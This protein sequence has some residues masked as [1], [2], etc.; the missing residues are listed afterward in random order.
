MLLKMSM[1][2]PRVTR[3]DALKPSILP[4]TPGA[5]L[6]FG[7]LSA[8]YVKDDLVWVKMQP[9]IVRLMP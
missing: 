9:L 3:C 6:M 2:V 8:L 4:I 7:S 1:I 5:D